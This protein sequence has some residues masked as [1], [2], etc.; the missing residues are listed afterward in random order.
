[1]KSPCLSENIQKD[2]I[3]KESSGGLII[4]KVQ[5]VIV[6]WEMLTADAICKEK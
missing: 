2:K 1:L 4:I 6:G 3:G 5:F